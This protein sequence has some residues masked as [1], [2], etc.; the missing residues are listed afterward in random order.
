MQGVP[1]CQLQRGLSSLDS[2]AQ[3]ALAE[4]QLD[5]FSDDD[6]A[7]S[8]LSGTYAVSDDTAAYSTRLLH[9]NAM[10]DKTAA[11]IVMALFSAQVSLG[12]A[13][14]QA[15]GVCSRPVSTLVAQGDLL[16]IN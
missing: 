6:P 7:Y 1:I 12:L 8:S 2:A 10:V 16:I 5:Y 15:C 4:Q 14:A 13:G 3:Q 9:N 11:F